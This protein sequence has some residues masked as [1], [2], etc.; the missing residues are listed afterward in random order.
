M[1]F[2]LALVAGG[3][4]ATTGSISGTVTDA[5]G[6]LVKGATVVLVNTDRNHV[7][8]TLTTSSAGFYAAT[9]LPLGRY[10]VKITDPGF[11]ADAVTGLMLNVADALTV[12]RKLVA[13]NE[14]E[15]VTVT[16]DEARVNLEDAT[17]AGLINTEQLNE[18]PLVTRN[19]ETLLN[20]Q[21]GVVYGGATDDLTRGPAGLSGSSSTVNFSVNG[22]RNT[23]NNWTIDGA[24][25]VDRGANLTLYTYPSPDAIAQFKT[26]RGQYSA[27]FGRNAS[28]Q[29]DV[30]TKSG[31]NN[32]HGSAYEYLRND[33]FDANGYAN[34]YLKMHI[35]A[36]RYNVFG[37]S[38]GGPVRIPKIYNGKDRTCFFV[39]EEWQRIVQSLPGT[40]ALVPQASERA[41]DFTQS[42]LK[43][44]PAG[45]TGATWTTGPVTVCTAYSTNPS[46][47]AN[48]CTATGTKVT[49]ISPL[50]QQ[51]LRDVYSK[52]PV[53]NVAQDLALNVDP[54]TIY[55]TFK[56]TFNN[57]DSVVR[58]DQSIGQKL[59]IFYRYVHD[60]FPELLP[61][62]QFTTVAIPGAN[63]TVAVNPGTQHLARGTYTL[64]PTALINV[65][66]ALSNGNIV[67]T[68]S[69]F[70]SSSQSTDIAPS[71]VYG[72]T[73]GVI[74]TVTVSGMA[75]LAGSIAYTD[76]GT[77][78]QAFGDFTKVMGKNTVIVGFSYDHY[79]KL[80]NNTTGTQGAFTFAND[81]GFSNVPT[82]TISGAAEAQGFA[83]FLTGNANGG[84]SQL[85]RDPVTDIK[86][87]LYEGFVQDNLKATRRLTVNLGVRYS[88]Y[89]QPW[90]ANGLLS[91]FSPSTYSASKA[92]TIASTGLDCFTGTCSQANS[93]AG[94]ATTPNTGADYVGI[95]YLNGMIYNGPNAANGMQASPYGNKVGSAQKDNFAPRFGFALDVFG[96]GRTALRGG[97]GWAFDDAE[98]SYYE[99]TVFNNPPSVAT[100][101]VSQTSFDSPAGG[102]TTGL[103]SSPGRVQALPLNYKTPYVQ[104]YSL[105][106]QQ[107]L[108][109]TFLLDVGYFGNHGTHLLGA[110]NLDQPMPGAWVGKVLPN[111]SGA[112]TCIDSDTGAQSFLNSTCDR[113]INQVRPYL[114]YSAIDSLRTIFSSNYNALQV[115][116]TKR[117]KDKSYIDANYTWSRDLTNAQADYSGF[118]QDIYNP[119]GDYGRAADDRNNV[120]T[121]DGV[122]E[123]PWYKDQKGLVGHVIGGWEASAIYALDSGL[124]LTVSASSTY[125]P[126]YN[127][128]SASVFNGRTTTGVITDNAGLGSLGAT[129]AG[130]R[131]NQI[132][133]PNNGYG[134]KIHNKGYNSL[135]FYTGAFAAA[136]PSQTTLAPTAKRGTIQGPGFNRLD[137]GIHRNFRIYERLNFQFRAEAFNAANHTNVQTIGT[138][139]SSATT[140]GE[141]TGYRDARILQFAGRLD[142]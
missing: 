78:H 101:S 24:D 27:E 26:L 5:S 99:T 46:T 55:S 117:F 132:G 53:P 103:S 129:S 14:G 133:N 118:V 38:V 104:Q 135:W 15:T 11:K 119:N 120:L 4:D 71:L 30:V 60:T 16:A 70:L 10:T 102:A 44:G 142:F 52:I 50:A 45:P 23:S 41:G 80:E 9:A 140:F 109:P 6:A 19:Y 98:V 69:G 91:N 112:S 128:P 64:S 123:L 100:Y 130:I 2:G 95:N 17:S 88:Y 56:N 108:T 113:V 114:G 86:E 58:I 105:D 36:Y 79:Q 63:T 106:V 59:N 73:V 139:A 125:S 21:P 107:A 136:P 84:F 43:N 57:L 85:S 48:T 75:N 47:Q 93:N 35:G 8:R 127:L 22:G 122:Y 25:N 131:L 37:F 96:N 67:S 39:S 115:K 134:T 61:Q 29:I 3:Q 116:A 42:G 7:E 20:L 97:Y 82:N 83:N 32:I 87:S 77:N 62:G 18:M 34:D 124:P 12:N 110:E 126:S 74:P 94:L 72:N 81:A 49:N 137:I 90:D 66:Y 141:V 68:P 31:T 89:G 28:G 13:G 92:P 138:A 111:N 1:F 54:H 76:H 121:M 51:Y 40:S 33:Y 65:G